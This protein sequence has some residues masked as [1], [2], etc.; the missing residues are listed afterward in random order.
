MT[1]P[2]NITRGYDDEGLEALD[3]ACERGENA[4]PYIVAAMKADATMGEIMTGFEEQ[5]G[6]YSEVIGLA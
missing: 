1:L 5:Y 3:E 2:A 4:M 6:A